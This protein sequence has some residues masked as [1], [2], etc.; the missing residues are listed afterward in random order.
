MSKHIGLPG[1]RLVFTVTVLDVVSRDTPFGPLGDHTMRTPEGDILI[2]AAS[3]RARWLEKGKT[4]SVKATIKTYDEEDGVKRT[5]LLRVDEYVEPDRMP[6]VAVG[7]R[8]SHSSRI[9]RPGR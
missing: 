5:I 3:Q 7:L 1:Q 6:R 9:R 8:R 2:W 4:Y